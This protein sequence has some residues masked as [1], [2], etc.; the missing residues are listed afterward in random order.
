MRIRRSR[1]V[2]DARSLD[3][4]I[5][6]AG[7]APLTSSSRPLSVHRG[8]HLKRG[9]LA[10]FETSPGSIAGL[11][12]AIFLLV[13]FPTCSY[14]GVTGGREPSLIPERSGLS[15]VLFEM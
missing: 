11:T 7:R 15:V 3:D 9:Q 5:T 6:R 1:Q 12:V 4:R 2:D 14:E 8:F 13:G 10:G